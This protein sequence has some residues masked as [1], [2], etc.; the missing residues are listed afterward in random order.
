MIQLFA[1]YNKSLCAPKLKAVPYDKLNV[2]K[3]VS[4]RVDNIL[5]K[6]QIPV[7]QHFSFSYKAFTWFD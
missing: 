2:M 1:L 5:G 4:D 3:F 7:K 6:G